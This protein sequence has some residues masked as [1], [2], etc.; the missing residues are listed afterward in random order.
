MA[1]EKADAMV[2]E[3]EEV[4]PDMEMESEME[5]DGEE[6]PLSLLGGMEV[7]PGD[8]VRITVVAGPDENGTWRGRYASNKSKG[9]AIDEMSEEITATG[10]EV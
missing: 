3:M 9:S 7:S 1:I 4:S 10:E 6:L 5:M 8:V 2:S